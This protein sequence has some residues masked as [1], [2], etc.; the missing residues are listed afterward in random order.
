[1][2]ALQDGVILGAGLDTFATEPLAADS[3]LLRMDNVV[4]TPHCAGNTVDNDSNMAA[5]CL[6]II[7]RYDETGDQGLS[8]IVNRQF[9][10][11][12]ADSSPSF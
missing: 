3:Q 1:M 4:T 2:R 6:E 11:A 10:P 5:T 12:F 9:L 8:A 7:L